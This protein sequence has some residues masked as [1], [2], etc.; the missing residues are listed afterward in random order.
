MMTDKDKLRWEQFGPA[1][2]FSEHKSG[3]IITYRVGSEVRVGEIIYVLAA[4]Q[5]GSVHHPLTYAVDSGN[6]F[7]DVVWQT[8]ILEDTGEP[9]LVSCP[10][11]RGMHQSDQVEQCPL[12]PEERE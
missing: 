10:Y 12:K 11:C 5:E 8:D 9:R 3:E 2:R 6:G 1:A 7:P 4:T